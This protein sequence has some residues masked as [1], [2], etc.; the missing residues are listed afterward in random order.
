MNVRGAFELAGMDKG[1]RVLED[2]FAFCMRRGLWATSSTVV[3]SIEIRE[4]GDD[5]VIYIGGFLG[6]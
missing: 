5:W 1:W 3:R 4:R 2:I 6:C